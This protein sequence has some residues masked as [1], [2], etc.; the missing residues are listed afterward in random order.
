MTEGTYRWLAPLIATIVAVVLLSLL[1][2]PPDNPTEFAI[3]AFLY[4]VLCAN[5]ST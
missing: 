1:G 2:H 5:L 4:A 3:V